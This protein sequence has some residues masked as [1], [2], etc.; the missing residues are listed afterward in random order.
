MS[1]LI[2][3][4]CKNIVGCEELARTMGLRVYLISCFTATYQQCDMPKLIQRRNRG[5][6]V[7]NSG[8]LMAVKFLFFMLL[9]SCF[10]PSA[11]SEFLNN[12]I[13]FNHV[14]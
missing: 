14:A 12:S 1:Y 3:Y 2:L 6:K 7:V 13:T 9:I 8:E 4:F 11:V 5:S 10:I